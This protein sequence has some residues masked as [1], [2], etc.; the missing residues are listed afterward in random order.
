APRF[1]RV[2]LSVKMEKRI[3]TDSRDVG[4]PKPAFA[5]AF[6]QIGFQFYA[7]FSVLFKFEQRRP[8]GKQG[9]RESIGEVIGDELREARR[10]AV[11]DVTAFVP[12]AETLA[13][14]GLGRT[15]IPV[16]LAFDEVANAGV[17]RRA[18]K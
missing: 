11:R 16:T 12:A 4:T 10:I 2:S 14:A 5:P 7:A 3:L 13:L 9:G 17:V 6:V 15:G 1:E 8:F 18:G